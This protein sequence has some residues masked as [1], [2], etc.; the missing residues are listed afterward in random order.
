MNAQAAPR[1]Q[2]RDTTELWELG[3]YRP[4]ATI[5]N[6]TRT[7]HGPRVTVHESPRYRGA[8]TSPPNVPGQLRPSAAQESQDPRT[9]LPQLPCG[10]HMQA[11]NIDCAHISSRCSNRDGLFSLLLPGPT[12][13][14]CPRP[15]FWPCIC[16]QGR[17][18]TSIIPLY[19]TV[20]STVLYFPSLFFNRLAR[21]GQALIRLPHSGILPHSYFSR[22]SPRRQATTQL[23]FQT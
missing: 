14:Q 5:L 10:M 19:S 7:R 15:A 11:L 18:P 6:D 1:K 13:Q 8:R 23:K 3:Y 16:H 12:V 20:R 4:Q 9:R 17:T 21:E 22:L 2:Q